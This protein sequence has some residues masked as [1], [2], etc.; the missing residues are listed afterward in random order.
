MTT[1]AGFLLS[2]FQYA[3]DSINQVVLQ[4]PASTRFRFIMLINLST[5]T[6]SQVNWLRS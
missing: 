4:S 3:F 1:G 5:C 2:C 6:Q